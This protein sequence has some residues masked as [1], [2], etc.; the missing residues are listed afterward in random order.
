VTAPVASVTSRDDD[1]LRRA[2][3][4]FLALA[5]AFRA[6]QLYLPNN[7]VR[8]RALAAAR[9]A[10]A[11]CWQEDPAP[12]RVV[13]HEAAFVM[14]GHVVHRQVDRPN[15]GV[16][17]LFYRDGVRELTL[18]P[19]FDLEALA[20]LLA[21]LHRARHAAPDHDDLVTLLWVA[22]FETLRYRCVEIGS[23]FDAEDS[24]LPVRAPGGPK[25][26]AVRPGQASTTA[27]FT[28]I[29]DGPP[30]FV[31]LDDF[32]S[33]L[34]FLDP[35]ELAYLQE[36]VRAEFESDPRRAVLATLFDIFEMQDD[37]V[38]RAEVLADLEAMLVELLATHAYELAAY[39]LREAR[40]A[41]A[42][43]P[44][45]AA[46]L[47]ARLASLSER[48]SEPSVVTQLLQ[49]IDE[50]TRAPDGDS[51]ELLVGELRGT[52]L[53]PLLAWLAHAPA[54]AARVAV[55]RAAA[56]LA[57]QHTTELARHVE[58]SDPLVALGA[59]RLCAR[60][61]SPA[62]VPALGR[63]LQTADA[64]DRLELVQALAAIASPGALQ[65]VEP[66]IE[67]A[68]RAVRV[69]ALRAITAHRYATARAR[70]LRLAGRKELRT[71]DRSEKASFFEAVGTVC[72]AAGVPVLAA[73][74]NGRSLLGPRESPE[75][76]ACAARALGLVDDPAARDALRRA[77][78]AREPVVRT[79]VA[80]ALRA[81]DYA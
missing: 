70:L 32:D 60:L 14:D 8:E 41:A 80:R 43:H 25:P 58:S 13:V 39:S 9:A 75:L 57:E 59:I 42:R 79:E 74:L 20:P 26:G 48:L 33:T 46:P 1:A 50:G 18:L 68:D 71:A 36:E 23:G 6:W 30:A 49:A 51:L 21:L 3:E 64:A 76:R 67:D 24:L 12:L 81:G 44:T 19:G 69:A 28:P 55:E 15:D 52:A 63:R 61:R 5:K 35:R 78:E 22:D 27:E 77:A 73:V 47:A 66:A 34:Y 4:A 72:G 45:L 54:G 11:A 56:R 65:L 37:P 10:F 38:I 16:P 2:E 40:V 17:W 53:A 7:P 31:R 29:G 62:V